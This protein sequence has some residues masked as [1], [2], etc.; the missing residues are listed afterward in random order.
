MTLVVQLRPQN[1]HA[2]THLSE[3]GDWRVGKPQDPVGAVPG[4]LI[5]LVRDS[6]EVLSGRLDAPDD[7][8]NAEPS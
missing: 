5:R 1:A 7:D 3:V 6:G 4:E 2:W 8:C